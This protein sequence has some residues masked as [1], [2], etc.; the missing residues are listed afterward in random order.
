MQLLT[1]AHVSKYCEKYRFTRKIKKNV[2]LIT[3]HLRTDYLQK[4]W[5]LQNQ[6]L[7]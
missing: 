5:K 6:E 1:L 3:Q 7:N 4:T 2:R